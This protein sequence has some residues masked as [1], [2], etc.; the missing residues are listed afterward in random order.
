VMPKAKK[1]SQMIKLQTCIL[2]HCTVAV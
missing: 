1:I 2:P